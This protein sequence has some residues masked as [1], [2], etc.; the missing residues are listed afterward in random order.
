MNSQPSSASTRAT[1]FV[2]GGAPAT[3][4]RTRSRPGI[5]PSQSGRLEHGGHHG[6]R[7]AHHCHAV[8]L[9][10]AQDLGA[11]DLAQ[12]DV[13]RPQAGHRERHAPAVGVEH[14]QRVQVD[15]AVADPG[16]QAER[17][18]VHPDVAVGDLHALRPGRGARGVVDGRRRV[19]VRLPRLRLRALERLEVVV[20][21]EHERALAVDVL[22]RLAPARGRR[23]GPGRRSARRCRH[24]V[25]R[26]RKLT[27]TSTRPSPQTPKN[28]VSRRA[29]LWLTTATRSPTADAEPSSRRLAARQLGDLGVGQARP[30]ARRAGPARRRSRAVAVHGSR[31]GRGSRRR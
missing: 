28:D 14:R 25:G 31:R 18:R 11:V 5:S 17:H 20:L 2:G 3:M 7:G 29:L 4:I 23:R 1:V 19:L 16:V 13:L 15:V 6:R 22:E 21:A 26:S 9:D 24:L 8:L 10:P 30:A 12:H 27:G